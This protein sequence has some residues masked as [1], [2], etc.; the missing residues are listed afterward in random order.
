MLNI[1][2]D[3][4]VLHII[5]PNGMMPI[6]SQT[7]L[8]ISDGDIFDFIYKHSVKMLE[9]TG[10]KDAIFS[11]GEVKNIVDEITQDNFLEKSSIVAHLLYDILY[12]Q[13]SIP[14]SDLLVCLLRIEDISFFSILKL[15]YKTG[16]THFVNNSEQG[17]SV[18]LIKH[19]AIL[20]ADGQKVDEGAFVNLDD[21]SIKLLEK[22]YEVDGEKRE[23]FS[24]LFLKCTNNKSKKEIVTVINKVAEKVAESAGADKF[25]TT[26]RIKET[27]HQ[28]AEESET[29]DIEELASGVFTHEATRA[30]YISELRQAGVEPHIELEEETVQKLIR[31]H[32]IKTD[33]GIEVNLPLALFN[34]KDTIEF[35]N[36]PDG[37]TSILIKNISKITNR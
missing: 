4:A 19:Q 3:K 18:Q 27:I 26:A 35:I 15:N 17:A 7:Q 22:K 12:K 34:D 30:T 36:N 21:L 25:T 13:P 9:D 10:I 1:I 5:D 33:K 37:T 2:V 29:V 8:D 24:E 11:G 28:L 23:Y 20:P 6:I 31:K 16:Y 14:K 32:R